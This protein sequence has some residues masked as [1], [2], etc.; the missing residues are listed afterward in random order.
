[1]N[2]E[3]RILKWKEDIIQKILTEEV[4]TVVVSRL[5]AVNL[6]QRP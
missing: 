3:Q 5:N 2:N 6:D 1:M 4:T